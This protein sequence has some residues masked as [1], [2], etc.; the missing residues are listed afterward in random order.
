MPEQQSKLRN[1]ARKH[2]AGKQEKGRDKRATR[3]ATVGSV[4]GPGIA[5]FMSTELESG[6]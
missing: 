1:E 6:S 2:S 4:R 3:S 5:S